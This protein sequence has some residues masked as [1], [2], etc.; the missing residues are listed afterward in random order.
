MQEINILIPLFS[1]FYFPPITTEPPRTR[2]I[3]YTLYFAPNLHCCIQYVLSSFIGLQQNLNHRM[4]GNTVQNP[5]PQTPSSFPLQID[6]NGEKKQ[7]QIFYAP[8][9]LDQ[10]LEAQNKST[11]L[12]YFHQQQGFDN[13]N[14]KNLF[15]FLVL[16]YIVLQKYQRRRRCVSGSRSIKSICF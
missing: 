15:Y 4:C 2:N 7:T 1:L 11:I 14:T 10:F 9:P 8:F 3:L 12:K 6:L 16:L 13:F 5:N